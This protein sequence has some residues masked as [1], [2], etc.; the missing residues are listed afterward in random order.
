MQGYNEVDWQIGN[1]A[2]VYTSQESVYNREEAILESGSMYL[3]A[4]LS[5]AQGEKKE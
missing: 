2:L 4:F 1:T 3:H 5:F